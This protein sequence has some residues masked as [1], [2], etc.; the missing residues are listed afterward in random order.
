MLSVFVFIEILGGADNNWQWGKLLELETKIEDSQSQKRPLPPPPP[1]WEPKSLMT[2]ALETFETQFQV[3]LPWIQTCP[4]RGLLHD[5]KLREGLLSALKVSNKRNN[6]C[7]GH[8]LESF[9]WVLGNS[10]LKQQNVP[11]WWPTHSW[12]IYKGTSAPDEEMI[13]ANQWAKQFQNV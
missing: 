1:G 3:C 2:F 13:N 12:N 9:W 4:S 10:P 5:C 8:K 11:E 6:T 7:S